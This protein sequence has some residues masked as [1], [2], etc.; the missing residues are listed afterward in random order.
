MKILKLTD[1]QKLFLLSKANGT[2]NRQDL[3]PHNGWQFP[4]QTWLQKRLQQ[5]KRG[6]A[7]GETWQTKNLGE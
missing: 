4:Q 1:N 3:L 2:N 5:I 7:I 6:Q